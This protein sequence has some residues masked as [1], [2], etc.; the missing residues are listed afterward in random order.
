MALFT[1]R[2]ALETDAAAVTVVVKSRPVAPVPVTVTVT[3][4]MVKNPLL[5]DKNAIGVVVASTV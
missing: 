1:V 5:R 4:D 3:N 2:R